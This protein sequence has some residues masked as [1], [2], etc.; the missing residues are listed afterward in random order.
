MKTIMI[1]DDKLNILEQFKD[2]LKEN[3]FK[4]ITVKNNREALELMQGENEKKYELLLIDSLT[5]GSKKPALFPMKPSNIKN[6]DITKDDDFL[7]KPFTNEE[8]LSF[9]KKRI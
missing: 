4:L 8:L 5:P 1:I 2:S 6:I 9:V 3:D 7:Q